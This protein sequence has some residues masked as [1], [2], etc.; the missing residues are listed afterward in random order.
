MPYMYILRCADD[1]FYVGSTWNAE[2]RLAEHNAG[3]GAKYTKRR[4][5]VELVYAAWFDRIDEAY[6]AEKQVQGWSRRKRQM[7]IDGRADALPGS[8]SRARAREE[9]ALPPGVT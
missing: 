5:P 7:L 8:G 2:R 4:R 6:A 1:S 9:R 3:T